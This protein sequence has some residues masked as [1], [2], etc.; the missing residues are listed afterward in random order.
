MVIVPL[1]NLPYP[2]P[3]STVFPV[4]REPTVT[5]APTDES[6]PFSSADVRKDVRESM[7]GSPSHLQVVD[8]RYT[9]F[10]LNPETGLFTTIRYVC[11]QSSVS[12]CFSLLQA[13]FVEI[14]ATQHGKQ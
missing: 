11:L 10:V 12:D 1:L 5:L 7:N 9:R 8:Y 6:L 3:I 4:F 2:Y 13:C 14:G